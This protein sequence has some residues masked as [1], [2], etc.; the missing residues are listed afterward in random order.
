MKHK[1]SEMT[2]ERVYYIQCPIERIILKEM[3]S[4][5]VKNNTSPRPHCLTISCEKHYLSSQFPC[6]HA[7]HPKT[8]A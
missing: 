3:I 6:S 4:I 8:H 2:N 1:I 5:I 7:N